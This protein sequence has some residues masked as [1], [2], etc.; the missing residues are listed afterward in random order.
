[1]GTL[2]A[3]TVAALL[4]A[5]STV[6]AVAQST[7]TPFGPVRDTS[8]VG[9]SITV[10]I[11]TPTTVSGD[12]LLNV[13]YFGDLRDNIYGEN[14]D[15]EVEGVSI[16]QLPGGQGISDCGGDY[17]A[18]LTIP[19]A[20]FAAAAADGT[21][22]VRFFD[23]PQAEINNF[24]NTTNSAAF[25]FPSGTAFAVQGT[26][27]FAAAAPAPG[28]SVEAD[29][30]AARASLI[31]G[32]TLSTSRRINRLQSGSGLIPGALSFAGVPLA[33]DIGADVQVTQNGASFATGFDAGNAMV[34]VEGS[35]SRFDDPLTD[36]GNFAIL[37]AGA[38]WLVTPDVMVGVSAQIDSF[39]QSIAA[40][41]EFDS[42]GWMIGP[43]ATARLD[44]NLYLD[45]RLAYGQADNDLLRG[46]A[47]DEFGSTRALA[48]VALIGQT[49]LGMFNV[50]PEAELLFFREE[51]DAYTSATVG[52]VDASE[53]TIGQARLGGQLEH[54]IGTD[55][56]GYANFYSVFTDIREGTVSDGS[57][58][59]EISGWSG[60]FGLGL[61]FANANGV[62]LNTSV[63][64]GGLF[65]DANS[66]TAALEVRIP[67]Q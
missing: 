50:F 42:R 38:D 35:F 55:A 28:G 51:T 7:G 36:G 40:G 29:L 59:D 16:G 62:T 65:T 43:V 45:G 33:S 6:G 31:T 37:H 18:T 66:M 8:S 54:A 22:S 56:V 12:A 63:G 48:E 39:E 2:R 23:G 3:G 5:S 15:V 10:N 61:R 4:L 9:G 47:T 14:I 49:S 58:I 21:V 30:V 1:M 57:F 17:T 41:E 52:A 32:N 19:A 13:T 67:L 25:S 34:W 11:A 24:C 26:L 27:N 53:V 20:T 44:E 64:V 60:E 46:G